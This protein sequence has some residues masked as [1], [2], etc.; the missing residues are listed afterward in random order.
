MPAPNPI[1]SLHQQLQ[2]KQRDIEDLRGAA[3]RQHQRLLGEQ[4]KWNAEM[5]DRSHRIIELSI[6]NRAIRKRNAQNKR[7]R[8]R[9]SE[10]RE[11]ALLYENEDLGDDVDDLRIEELRASLK[12]TVDGKLQEVRL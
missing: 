6:L 5:L 7:L 11:L 4:Q 8:A 9:C 12:I 1:V 2:A 3:R 10:W